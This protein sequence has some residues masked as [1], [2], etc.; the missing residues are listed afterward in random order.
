MTKAGLMTKA[1]QER[2]SKKLDHILGLCS[3]SARSKCV[4]YKIVD[5]DNPP[6]LM[7]RAIINEFK[8]VANGGQSEKKR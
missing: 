2:L 7:K 6:L 4:W 8:R 5:A 3:C 1:E